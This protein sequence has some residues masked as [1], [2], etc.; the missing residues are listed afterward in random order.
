M[1]KIIFIG[2]IVGKIGRRAVA[3]QLPKLKKKY[4]PDV[5]IANVENL[6]HGAGFTRSSLDEIFTAGVDY[7]T[8]G[9]HTFSKAGTDEILNDPAGRIIRPANY[10]ATAAGRSTQVIAI[11]NHE[12]VITNLLGQVFMKEEVSSPFTALDQVI[13]DHPDA[14]IFVDMH[15]EATSEK[16][17]IARHG[18]GRVVTVVGTHTHVPTADQRILP[19]GTGFVTDVGMV[20]AVDSIIGAR[21]DQILNVFLGKGTGNKKHDLPEVGACQF[22][23]VLITIDE[24]LGRTIAIERLDAIIE[25]V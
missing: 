5:V 3:K 16:L 10:P 17:A 9:N 13:A 23:A 1:I 14:L 11:G 19:G 6:A 4:K 2:D 24:E 25:V 20:G 22:N 8:G 21:V 15:C 12:L 18:D 7:G